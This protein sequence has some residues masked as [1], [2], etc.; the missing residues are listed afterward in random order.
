[1]CFAEI[2]VQTDHPRV[3]SVPTIKYDEK[4]VKYSEKILINDNRIVYNHCN[5]NRVCLCSRKQRQIDT[6]IRPTKQSNTRMQSERIAGNLLGDGPNSAKYNAVRCDD[7]NVRGDN[8]SGCDSKINNSGNAEIV[9]DSLN[10]SIDTASILL[11]LNSK[12]EEGGSLQREREKVVMNE[13]NEG[14][15][16][17]PTHSI[18]H[19]NNSSND[20]TVS[21]TAFCI[22]SNDVDVN[23]KRFSFLSWNVNGLLSKIYDTECIGFVT[24]FDFICLVETFLENFSFDVFPNHKVFCKPAIRFPGRGRPSGGVIVLIRNEYVHFT[25]QLQYDQFGNFLVFAIDKQL[26]NLP[27]DILYV[28]TYVPPEG[29]PF[30]ARF[31]I[32]NGIGLLEDCLN[33]CLVNIDDFF[34]LLTGDLNS[35][36]ADISQHFAVGDD[37]DD[38]EMFNVYYKSQSV[39]EGRSSQD[40]CMN[41]YGK[42]LLNLCTA[43]ELCILN[44]LCYGDRL[45]RCTYISDSGSSVNDYF[46]LSKDLF[47]ILFDT[48]KLNVLNRIESDHMP[49]SFDIYF[50]N[51]SEHEVCDVNAFVE[52]FVWISD[53]KLTFQRNMNSDD[54]KEKMKLATDMIDVDINQALSLFNECVKEAAECMKKKVFVNRERKKQDW[55]DHECKTQRKLTRKTLNR[56]RCTM[57][58]SDRSE[59]C[60]ARREYKNLLHRKRKQYNDIL[61]SNLVTSIDDQHA[62]WCAVKNI[63]FKQRSVR[64]SVSIDVWFE[65]FKSLL[66]KQDNGADGNLFFDD[67]DDVNEGNTDT[68]IDDDSNEILNAPILKEEIIL[69]LKKLKNKKAAGPDGIV[70]ELLKNA[71]SIVV[72]FFVQFLNALFNR[73]IYPDSWIESIVLPLYKKGD[74][75][76]PGNY[77]GISLSNISSKVYASVINTRLTKWVE[78]NN[79]TG[80]WQAGFKKGYSTIDHMFTL[81]ASVQKQFSS[82]RKLYVAFIDFEKCFDSINRNLLWPILLKN[83]IKGKCFNCIR[84]MY[85]SVKT[86]VRSGSEFSD[87][88]TCSFGVKQG[89]ICSPILFSLFI[90]ELALKVISN[91]RHGLTLSLDAFTLFIMLL[92]D[93]VVLLSETVV[94]LQTQLNNLY[95]AAFSLQLKVNM[96]KSNIIVFRKGGYLAAREHWYYNGTIMPVTNVYKYLGI[97]FS[98]RL[99]FSAA[100]QDLASRAKN[101]LRY[102]LRKLYILNNNSLSVFLKLFDSCV[103]PIAQYGAELWALDDVASIHVEKLHLFAL[104]KFLGV[105][106]R[107]PND[108]VYGDTGRYPIVIHSTIRCIKYWLKLLAMPDSRLPRKVYSMLYK[109][110]EGGK[111]NWVSKIRM[112]L[113]QHGFGY[114]WVNQSVGDC[115][116]FIS[117]LRERMI[118]CRWQKW[119]G[120]VRESE[121]FSTYYGFNGFTHERKLYLRLDLNRHIKNVVVKFRFGISELFVHQ[122]RYRNVNNITISLVCPLCRDATENEVHFILCCPS[123]MKLRQKLIHVKYYKNP[124]LNHLNL[125]LASNQEETVRNLAWY[126]YKAFKLRRNAMS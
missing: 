116:A 125:L 70:G 77:R 49:L 26:F 50:E 48:C 92:A 9:Y 55:F 44:G 114:V 95:N 22:T 74:V 8:Y 5:V 4:I 126:L 88:I 79:V 117:V 57:Q 112:F 85:L 10:K 75:N 51:G 61:I 45:G 81:M 30:Y 53:Y 17:F 69:A 94:G 87:V 39:N 54:M 106:I 13:S 33:D 123:L 118:D 66:E 113:F 72:D 115:N 76:N 42:L 1:M 93:D 82:N 23:K 11:P 12:E 110:D 78:L 83:N 25:R 40:S 32:D 96:N 28:G 52:K 15:R 91:G 60:I 58:A 104:K 62:F 56:F 68:V 36:T 103:Q 101:A 20:V 121:R 67:D 99:S 46:I 24:S 108:L 122:Y 119:E 97:M 90:N 59:Y 37:D 102:I 6:C 14:L 73:G 35:R 111:V 43:F 71:G 100:C 107:T 38:E 41:N 7:S 18:E 98:T 27:K 105:D 64:N 47:S 21:A 124:N 65:H 80:E 120:H 84:S 89:C 31:D 34:V 2:L 86:R 19:N 63:S 16:L 109:L 3:P 29:S